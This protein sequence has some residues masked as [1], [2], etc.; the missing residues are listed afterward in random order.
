[1][2]SALLEVYQPADPVFVEGR[3]ATLI[4]EDGKE[5]V[6]FAS[7]IAVNAL[8]YGDA[9][10]AAAI[11]TALSSGV[12][13]TSNLYRTRPGEELA[14]ALV[15]Q[16]FAD[17]VFFCNSGA[18]ANEAAFKFARRWARE[19]GGAEKHEVVALKGSFHGRLFGALAAT[20]RP[21][22]REPF[23]PLMPGVRFIEPGDA[24]AARASI[25]AERTAA[26]IVEPIQG[27]GGVRPIDPGFLQLLRELA[28]QAGAALIF[29][30][31]QCGL[32]RTGELFAY[33]G[34]GVVPDLMTL[35]K[36]LAGGLPMGAVLLSDRVAGA[37]RVG[38]HATTFG[39]GPL[40]SAAALAVLERVSDP[41]FLAGVRERGEHVV[42][43]LQ[44]LV[45][46]G[47][48]RGVR[49]RGLLLGVELTQ[50]ASEVVARGLEAGVL[51]V[52][53]GA[54]VVR[55][56]PPLS[57]EIEELDRGLALLSGVLS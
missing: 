37:I 15:E 34:T 6:D 2:S 54:D 18:E 1:M 49:G 17:R 3:G 24:D 33:Q 29:D 31:V 27:E 55:V 30:E 36:P 42:A 10:L 19:S 50:S 25:T 20:D 26:I 39:G 53:A 46:E 57:I 16:S 32:G 52:P 11:E 47:I 48:V 41:S 45:G 43:A 12:I 14:R 40:V 7:G 22:Y 51:L 5:Y 56:I 9:G 4:S 8:G 28:D 23:E 38:D 21:A 35:A 13:H 44:P